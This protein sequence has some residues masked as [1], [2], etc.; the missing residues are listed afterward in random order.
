VPDLLFCFGEA[1]L[2]AVVNKV[3]CLLYCTYEKTMVTLVYI[4]LLVHLAV[5]I[6]GESHSGSDALFRFAIV[7]AA[8]TVPFI[9][10][11]YATGEKPKWMWG[12]E[13]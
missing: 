13:K 5:G 7:F 12:K 4:L 11:C 6:D 3:D 1:S 8:L 10:I 9:A 2:V